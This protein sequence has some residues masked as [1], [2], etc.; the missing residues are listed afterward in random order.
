LADQNVFTTDHTSSKLDTA[1]A[2]GET[3]VWGRAADE[4][5]E[6]LPERDGRL[7]TSCRSET[8]GWERAAGDAEELPGNSA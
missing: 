8:G 1:G 5:P 7:G 6:T 2:A 4:P 3:G